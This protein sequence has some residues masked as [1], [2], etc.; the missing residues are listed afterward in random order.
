M[1]PTLDNVYFLLDLKKN[2]GYTRV[3]SAPSVFITVAAEG[4]VD[5]SDEVPCLP[6]QNTAPISG[7][8]FPLAVN[9]GIQ[10]VC[11][12]FIGDGRFDFLLS[13]FLIFIEQLFQPT[14]D[15]RFFLYYFPILSSLLFRGY[16]LH[17]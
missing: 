11:P 15:F 9:P 10:L 2:R 13:G 17:V 1:T 12:F 3:N 7:S 14:T 16:N 5:G 6:H 4:L 8:C